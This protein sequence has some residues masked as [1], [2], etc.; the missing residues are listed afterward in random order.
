M[1]KLNYFGHSLRIFLLMAAL[2]PMAG[3]Q[4]VMFIVPAQVVYSNAQGSVCRSLR[5]SFSRTFLHQ[6]NC[7]ALEKLSDRSKPKIKVAMTRDFSKTGPY[8]KKK[9]RQVHAVFGQNVFPSESSIPLR[10]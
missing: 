7:Q 9:L 8:S 5:R 6:L 4:W 2:I 1:M 3:R 10:I